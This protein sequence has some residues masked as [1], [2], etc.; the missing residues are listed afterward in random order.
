MSVDSDGHTY[1]TVR[2]GS[3]DIVTPQATR[4]LASATTLLAQGTAASP[5]LQE[6]GSAIAFDDFDTFNGSRDERELR[7]LADA[8]YVAPASPGSTTSTRTAAG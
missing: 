5:V 8:A 6:L 1:V 2:S 7:A 4:V 3:A